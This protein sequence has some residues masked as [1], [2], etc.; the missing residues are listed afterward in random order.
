MSPGIIMCEAPS[1]DLSHPISYNMLLYNSNATERSRINIYLFCSNSP[2]KMQSSPCRIRRV[3][4]AVGHHNTA[5]YIYFFVPKYVASEQFYPW[6]N[7]ELYFHAV[8]QFDHYYKI[9]SRLVCMTEEHQTHKF[10]AEL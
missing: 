9:I 4:E 6:S 1:S 10:T 8:L 3:S 2:S 5:L 7:F